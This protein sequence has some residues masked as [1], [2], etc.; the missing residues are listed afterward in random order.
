MYSQSQEALHLSL[1]DPG[2]D[3]FERLEFW[4]FQ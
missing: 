1:K 3:G 4:Y 2:I